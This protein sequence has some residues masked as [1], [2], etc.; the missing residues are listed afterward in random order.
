MYCCVCEA[1]VTNDCIPGQSLRVYRTKNGVTKVKCPV[2]QLH[3]FR[4]H[5]SL[6]RPSSPAYKAC[7]GLELKA[8]LSSMAHC[9]TPRTRFMF[10]FACPILFLEGERERERGITRAHLLVE[11]LPSR[12]WIATCNVTRLTCFDG[13]NTKTAF[14]HDGSAVT[15]MGS[16]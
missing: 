2:I 11:L 13:N 12:V 15:L 1:C 10:L 5:A 4:L 9:S 14:S 3:Q 16:G 7:T 8:L 6:L